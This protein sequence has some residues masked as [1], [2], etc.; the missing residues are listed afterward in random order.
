MKLESQ[1]CFKL[2]RAARTMIRLYQPLLESL[3]I[4]YPQYITLLVLWEKECIDFKQLGEKLDLKT[5]TLTPIIKK[6]EKLG[7]VVRERNRQDY[8]K[9]WV[10]L[11]PEGMKL[12]SEAQKI[13]Q[14]LTQQL[15][16]NSDQY[17]N[18]AA[19]LDEIGNTLAAAEKRQR[20]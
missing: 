10:K 7:Y 12:R 8:R 3:Q 15:E 1:I 2:Y 4:T 19:V 16:V 11:T 20:K 17:V 5:G 13:P 6:L 9:I 18:Y 14:L